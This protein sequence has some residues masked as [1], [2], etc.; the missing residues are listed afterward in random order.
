M[1]S[2]YYTRYIDNYRHNMLKPTVIQGLTDLDIRFV[3][4]YKIY[5]NFPLE[6]GSVTKSVKQPLIKR[7]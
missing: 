4:F 6:L 3:R 2:T 5:K 1:T 7:K